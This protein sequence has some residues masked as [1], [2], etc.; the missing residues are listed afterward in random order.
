MKSVIKI[1]F[2]ILILLVCILFFYT[3]GINLKYRVAIEATVLEDDVFQLFYLKEDAD[4]YSEAF[5]LKQTVSGSADAQVL[6]FDLPSE[7]NI[8]KLRVD[9]GQNEYQGEIKLNSISI[10]RNNKK[11]TFEKGEIYKIFSPNNFISIDRDSVRLS[12]TPV[13]GRYDPFLLSADITEYMNT[14]LKERIRIEN[15]SLMLFATTLIAAFIVIGY[16][17]KRTIYSISYAVLFLIILL[18]PFAW[19]L[20]PDN[21]TDNLEKRKLAEKPIFNFNDIEGYPKK[22]ESYFDDNFGLRSAL[23]NWGSLIK[24]KY[25]KSSNNL[26]KVA[27][28]KDNWLFLSGSFD[29]ILNDFSRKNLYSKEELVSL[30]TIWELREKYL[31]SKNIRYY[32]AFWPNKH[33]IYA[34]K[35]PLV[36]RIQPLDTLSRIDQVIKYLNESKSSVKLVDVRGELKDKKK[37]AQL[38]YKHDTHWNEYGAF[39]ASSKLIN[40]I[41][42]DYP[43]VEPI[44]INDFRV[45]WSTIYGGG[46]TNMLGIKNNKDYKDEK[47]SFLPLK[48]EANSYVALST[49][50]FP[51]GTII[52]NNDKCSN[53]LTVLIF[54]D[55][56]TS[57][58]IKFLSPHFNKSI[59]IWSYYNPTIVEKVN[60][61]IVIEAYVE[62][63]LK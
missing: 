58:M 7:V 23:I 49:E 4:A 30:I 25:F 6:Y 53:D 43:Q 19:P 16:H 38:Y 18:I 63:L 22:F 41:A 17:Y 56:F 3:R 27:L 59:Y 37:E 14:P 1:L 29:N 40:V 26:D 42:N 45:D 57:S 8:K 51:K 13:N 34:E 54:R 28:G 36:I 10:I 50:G 2:S 31:A 12:L 15:F 55:S 35:L 44:N 52:S 33:S 48:E 32:K 39:V 9:I 62:R 60:P 5:S 21:D 47:P 20:D 11:A 24:I 46:L 61:D